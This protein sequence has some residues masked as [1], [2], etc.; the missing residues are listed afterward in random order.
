MYMPIPVTLT[1]LRTPTYLGPHHH[2]DS[3][4]VSSSGTTASTT[5]HNP[6]PLSPV[7]ARGEA[8]H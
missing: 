1:T 4:S 3:S 8:T 7:T 6:N 2:H 5:P